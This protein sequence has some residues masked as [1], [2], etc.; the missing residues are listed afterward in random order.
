MRPSTDVDA[1][2]NVDLE[3]CPEGFAA[4][5]PE[6]G[7]D[8]AGANLEVVVVEVETDCSQIVSTLN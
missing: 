2:Q 3:C 5:V 8:A 7:R 6:S 1:V 4:D